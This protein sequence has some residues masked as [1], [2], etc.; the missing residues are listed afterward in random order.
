MNSPRHFEYD[1]EN[2]RSLSSNTVSKIFQ[3]EQGIMWI[4]TISSG[5]NKVVPSQKRF[6][7]LIGRTEILKAVG[8]RQVHN[9]LEDSSR[10]LWMGLGNGDLYRFSDY[11]TTHWNISNQVSKEPSALTLIYKDVQQRLW[12][13]GSGY[14]LIQFSPEKGILKR[15][16]PDEKSNSGIAFW[17]VTAIIQD[18][19]GNLWLGGNYN[20]VDIFNPDTETFVNYRN[21]KQNSRS[22]SN[23]IVSSIIKDSDNHIFLFTDCFASPCKRLILLVGDISPARI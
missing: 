21:N 9:F 16:I 8:T 6:Y 23:D 22:I 17:K 14:G 7:Q 15:F 11:G 12:I 1:S 10:N 4:G 18:R 3:D 5:I 13:S 2:N 20:G 19:R